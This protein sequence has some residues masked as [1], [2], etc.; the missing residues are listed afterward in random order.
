MTD[1]MPQFYPELAGGNDLASLFEHKL[2]QAQA[3]VKVGSRYHTKKT[4]RYS[5]NFEQSDRIAGVMLA[6][7]ERLFLVDLWDQGVQMGSAQ[8]PDLNGAVGVIHAF[9]ADQLSTAELHERFPFLT[10]GDQAQ[11]HELG[12]AAEVAWQWDNVKRHAAEFSPDLLPLL[13]TLVD[14]PPFNQLFPYM[15]LE[16]L[17]FSRC[18]GCPYT[19]DCPVVVALGTDDYEVRDM[20]G[21]T[22]GRGDKNTALDL[23][24]TNTPPT[25]GPAVQ[26]NAI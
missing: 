14:R 2:S 25:F 19:G 16:A 13:N 5:V 18:T 7:E 3:G 20:R 11:V 9:L 12:A 24:I 22:F 15:S 23:L 1:R 6:A 26:G 17:C 10:I 4:S 21:K 8:T